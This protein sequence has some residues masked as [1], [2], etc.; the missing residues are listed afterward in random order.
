MLVL[1]LLGYIRVDPPHQIAEEGANTRLECTVKSKSSIPFIV[2]WKNKSG[3]DSLIESSPDES[4]N[5]TV[6]LSLIFDSVT[7]EDYQTYIC[8]GREEDSDEVFVNATAI[9]SKFN[10]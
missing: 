4:L 1:I 9:L 5:G 10:I 2:E 3:T 6:T 7:S 8:I